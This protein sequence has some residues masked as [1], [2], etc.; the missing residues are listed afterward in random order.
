M[1]HSG[2]C[3]RLIQFVRKLILINED[4]MKAIFATNTLRHALHPKYQKTKQKN[5]FNLNYD[6]LLV[7]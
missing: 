6:K 3:D 2:P 5:N 7:L 1:Y 4:E